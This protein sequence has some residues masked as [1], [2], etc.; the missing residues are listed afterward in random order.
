MN[1]SAFYRKI[2]NEKFDNT[3][4]INSIKNYWENFWE[5]EDNENDNKKYDLLEKFNPL[6][7]NDIKFQEI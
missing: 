5:R 1:R 2:K 3:S 4:K 6:I 7:N